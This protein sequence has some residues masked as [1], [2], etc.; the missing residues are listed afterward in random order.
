VG[1]MGSIP[2]SLCA[3]LVLGTVDTASKYL[4]SEWGSLLFFV[5]MGL[6]LAWRPRGILTR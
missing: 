5:A 4:V 3:A 2:G 6:L 1:G